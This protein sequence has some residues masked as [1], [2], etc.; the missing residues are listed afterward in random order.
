MGFGYLRRP[1]R[2]WMKKAGNL[3]HGFRRTDGEF[4]VIFDADFCPRRDFLYELMPYMSSDVAIV[5][6]PQYFRTRRD[7]G[8][9]ERG[10][11]AVQEF[12][13]RAVQVSRERRGGAICVG[14]NA[15]YRRAA[16]EANG[17]ATL[18]EHSEDVHTGFD[19]RRLGWRVRYVPVNLATGLCPNDLAGF[20]RQQ[21]RWCMGSMSLLGSRKFWQTPMPVLTR[22]CYLSGFCYYVFTAALTLLLPA[23]PL[24]LLIAYP[25]AIV[26]EN[27][28]LLLPGFVFAL[29]VF[30]RWHRSHYGLEAWTVKAIYG[31]AHLFALVDLA[32]R[33]RMGWQATG[34]GGLADER[35]SA[36]RVAAAIWSGGAAL[37]WC[38]L[39][40]SHLGSSGRHLDFVPI[41][42]LGFFYAATIAR[43]YAPTGTA[44]GRPRARVRL[45]HAVAIGA[46]GLCVAVPAQAGASP[47]PREGLF[48]VVASERDF[49]RWRSALGPVSARMTFHAWSLMDD[50]TALLVAD[51]RL[52]TVPVI[53]W[54]PW[55]PPPLG[56]ADQGARQLRYANEAIAE[57]RWDSYLLRWAR[58]LRDFKRPIVLRVAHEMQGSWYPWSYDPVAFREAWRR[59]WRLFRRHG[60]GNVVWLWS[61]NADVGR[62]DAR[63]LA[64]VAPYWPGSRYVDAVAITAVTFDGRTRPAWF[65]ERLR[66]VA[67]SYR[68]PGLFSEVNV[69]RRE[70][71]GWLAELHEALKANPWVRGVIWS[72]ATSRGA[73]R[74]ATDVQMDSPVWLDKPASRTLRQ[75]RRTVQGP[76]SHVP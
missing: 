54:E 10:A 34:K 1:D 70:R 44:A 66:L 27:Y 57:G 42:A 11:G 35:T 13:Y 43:M 51:R 9:L 40:I 2:G 20:F 36:F 58:A 50:P 4:L 8:W 22:C 68:K 41:T 14:S 67:Q 25:S 52:G 37:A 56:T 49:P 3:R 59:M 53:T 31:W 48:G 69:E 15:I 18:I 6:S 71:Y 75:I 17:G 12:F 32:R 26:L 39:S 45:R 29:L 7:Q 16:L 21:Y 76:P 63:L 72:Q 64:A 55:K 65:I 24:V 74:H 38:G 33:R 73:H 23:V 60:V 19:V 46:V 61:V 5:Q 62:D 30:P 28:A 47:L